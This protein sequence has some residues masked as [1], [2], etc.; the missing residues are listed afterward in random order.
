[1]TT[2]RKPHTKNVRA[3]ALKIMVEGGSANDVHVQ[4]AIPLST[5]QSWMRDVINPPLKWEASNLVS[6]ASPL[7]CFI[8]DLTLRD[9]SL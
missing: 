7:S 8:A 6:L 3:K 9:H 5:A 4:L 1:M 2:T